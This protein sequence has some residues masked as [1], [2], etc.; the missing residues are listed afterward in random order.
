MLL[1]DEPCAS[2][3]GR[4]TREIEAILVDARAAGTRVVMATHDIGQ[5]RRLADDVLFLLNG[6]LHEFGPAGS[7]FDA[8]TTEEAQAFLDGQI[9]D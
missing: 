6:R 8:P 1:L 7:F 3:D 2:L 4:A 9:V 5:A